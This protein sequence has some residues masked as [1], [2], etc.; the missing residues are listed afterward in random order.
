MRCIALVFFLWSCAQSLPGDITPTRTG[1]I[2]GEA[3]MTEDRSIRMQLV[4][5]GCDGIIAH[6][7]LVV[8]PTDP[9]YAETLRHIGGLEPGQTKPVPAWPTP[10]CR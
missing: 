5:Y 7:Q 8:S 10:P 2:I 6:G 3:T 9:S 1:D 4:S